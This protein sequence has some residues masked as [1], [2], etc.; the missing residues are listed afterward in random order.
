MMRFW[1]EEYLRPVRRGPSTVTS[2]VVHFGLIFLA[3]LAT[4][5]PPGLVSLW[6]MANRVYYLAPPAR[7]ATT[8]ESAERM[9]YVDAAP[10]G[11]GSGFERSKV[12]TG[13]PTRQLTFSQPGD[14]GTEL[15]ASAESRRSRGTDSVFT[16]IEVDS[17]VA[18]DPMSAAP[19]YPEAMRQLGIE[20]SV[21]VRYIVDSTGLADSSSLVV[22]RASREDF[23]LAVRQALPYMH[24]IA[25]TIGPKRVSQLVIQDFNFK[26]ERQ[27]TD[28]VVA[29]ASGKKPPP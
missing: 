19:T 13:E 17:A 23:A 1:R 29:R 12:P 6:E 27:K 18:T 22:V 28:T 25:A 10:V 11:L 8:E 3:V 2:V 24:F 20:G 5:P 9:Q 21:Q 15:A 16:L 4:N 26:I 14:L 7:T